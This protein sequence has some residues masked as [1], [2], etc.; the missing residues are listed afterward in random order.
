M[1]DRVFAGRDVA[2]ALS[3]A[4]QALGLRPESL[5]YVVLDAGTPG[6]LGLKPTPARVAVLLGRAAV[7][8]SQEP[9][10]PRPSEPTPPEPKPAPGPVDENSLTPDESGLPREA[11]QVVE[12]FAAAAGVEIGARATLS[13]DRLSIELFGREVATFLLGPSEPVVADALEHLLH[14][15][16]AHRIT[17]R[18]LRVQFEGQREQREERLKAMARELA[19]SVLGDGQPRTTEPLNAYERRLI[20]MA[21]AEQPGVITYSVGGGADRRVTVAPEKASL[22]GE[23][24]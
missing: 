9:G 6:G 18:R 24:Y 7:A 16:F 10:R 13:P 19:A 11:E 12:A 14:G 1:S 23:I 15:M 2:D 21:V 22:G 4:A 20:H 3:T 8:S 5:R 17:P